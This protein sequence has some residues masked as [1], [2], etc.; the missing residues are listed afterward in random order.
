M[1]HFKALFALMSIFCTR[2]SGLTTRSYTHLDQ[3][4]NVKVQ[5]TSWRELWQ[6]WWL[7]A[8]CLWTWNHMAQ[9]SPLTGALPVRGLSAGS[10]TTSG[11]QKAADLGDG[12][13]TEA[14]TATRRHTQHGSTASYLNEP[15]ELSPGSSRPRI[16][17]TFVYLFIISRVPTSNK[18]GFVW[19]MCEG[20]RGGA[21]W[22]QCLGQQ[23]CWRWRVMGPPTG[24]QI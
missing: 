19:T 20:V 15:P 4:F 18:V 23:K 8:S 17:F 14:P 21:E 2:H 9:R 24:W 10:R 5:P 11:R 13:A 7:K 3:L 22:R 12:C 1:F 16:H 6:P